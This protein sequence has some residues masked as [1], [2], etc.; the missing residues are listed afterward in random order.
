MSLP[1][2]YHLP[3]AILFGITMGGSSPAAADDFYAGKV[4]RFVVGYSP[5]G[6]YDTVTRLVARHI[7]NHIPG[8]PATTVE[9]MD[10]AGSLVAANYLYNRADPDG[11]TVGVWNAQNL[12]EGAMGS[13]AVKL[14]GR[15]LEWIGSPGGENVVCAIMGFAGLKSFDEIQKSGKKITMGATRGGNTVHLPLILNK[16]TGTKF[17]IIRGYK[18]TAKIRLAMTSKE[19]NG[20]CWTWISMRTTARA[21]L[22][23][24]GDN[25]LI[26]FVINERTDEPEVKNIARFRDILTGQNRESFEIWSGPGEMARPFSIPP[27]TPKERVGILRSAFNATFKDPAFLADAK[28]SK[29]KV[30]L[31]QGE[32]VEQIAKRIYSMTPEVKENLSF[33]MSKK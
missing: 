16:W 18:G 7:G 2:K 27:G 17:D 1:F 11:L 29:F 8:K 9:N 30:E 26:P 23:A 14:D 31:V 6:G 3:L 28:K 33:L 25:K 24:E 5:G 4:I 32:K 15:K 22:I 10:G 12:F 21:M 19:V 13:P 20:A